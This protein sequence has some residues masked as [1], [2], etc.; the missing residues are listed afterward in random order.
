MATVF[1]IAH[2]N[3]YELRLAHKNLR[4]IDDVKVRAVRTVAERAP[5]TKPGFYGTSM[6]RILMSYRTKNS[7]T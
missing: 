6:S 7:M 1:A 4:G 2:I 5:R 3:S